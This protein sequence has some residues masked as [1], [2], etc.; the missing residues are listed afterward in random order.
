MGMFSMTMEKKVAVVTFDYRDGPV[1]VWG[2]N[3]VQ[4]LRDMCAQLRELPAGSCE[5]VV[6]ISGK[7]DNFHAGA[8]LNSMG[9]QSVRE[10]SEGIMVFDQALRE[11]AALP[12]P[13]VAAINGPCLG[14]GFEFAL[15]CTARIATGWKKTSMGLPEVGVGLFSAGGGTQRLPRL[16][17]Y[18][19]IDMI[20]SAK[21]VNAAR[22]K[23]LGVVDAVCPADGDLRA[24]AVALAEGIAAGTV[25]LERPQIDF[26]DVDA[27]VEK[28]LAAYRA[29]KGGRRLPAPEY[30]M[31]SL[32]EGAKT[33]LD[34]GLKLE[35]KYFI[36]HVACSKEAEGSIHTFQLKSLSSKAKNMIAPGYT[37]NPVK[38]AAVIG[39]GAMGRGIVISMLSAMAIPVVV[40]DAPEAIAPGMA[41]V[42]KILKKQAE[43]GRVKTP[44]DDLMKLVIPVTEYGD[45]LKDV[46]LVIEAVFEDM[47]VK[48]TVYGE[49]CKVIPDTCILATNTSNLLVEDLAKG[50]THPERFAGLHFFSPVWLMELVEVIAAPETAPEVRDDLIGFVTDLRKRPLVCKDSP[51]FVA[52]SVMDPMMIDTYDLLE[53]GCPIEQLDRAMK[54]FG[55]PVGPVRLADE[56]GLDVSYHIFTERNMHIQTLENM[57]NDHRYGQKKCGKGF[58]LADGTVDPDAVKLI[59][60]RERREFTD[61]EIQNRILEDQ[62]RAGK[63]LLDSGVVSDP[64]FI[65]IGMLWG[66]NYPAD[67]G[68]PMKW[69]DLSGMSM[70]LFGKNFYSDGKE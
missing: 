10:R 27:E 41:F 31:R 35:K 58:F 11:V 54:A 67:K 13:T 2:G 26:S 28:A 29:K 55:M 63:R 50:A 37:P 44:V 16:I 7:P 8:D 43:K 21:P 25:G 61:E 6:F 18:P 42:E 47:K 14:G 5:A 1:N 3:A 57:V 49:L 39:F 40:K 56:I 65:D 33:T 48:H 53:S 51:G 38:K 17:G 34:E 62:V 36:D 52:N 46:D 4:E 68:G 20:L 32:A 9:R 19:A 64:R 12:V 59:A 45:E 24:Q 30:A 66:S 69:S 60:V 15:S 22:A 70:R 23:E